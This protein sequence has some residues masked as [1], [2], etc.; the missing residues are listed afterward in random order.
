MAEAHYRIGTVARLSGLSTHVIR[1]WE[2]RYAVLAPD[3]TPG[4]ARLYDDDDVARLRF[5][6][7]AVDAGH[8][9]GTLAELST[10]ELER[11]GA[12]A[13][14]ALSYA[15]ETETFVTDIVRALGDFDGTRAE[16]ILA[17]AGRELSPRSLVIDVLG[18]LLNRIGQEWASG[19]LC[20]ASEH[21]G[22]V[23]IR[24]RLGALIREHQPVSSD[25]PVVAATPAGEL[26]ELGALLAVAIATLRGRR[27]LYL[28]PDL[29]AS[30]IAKAVRGSRSRL[31]LL[32]I[33]A[34]EKRSAVREVKALR[35]ELPATV[36]L[37]LGGSSSADVA[38]S[39]TPPLQAL[40]SLIELDE[41]FDRR[42]P[43]G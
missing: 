15:A 27:V 21:L 31:L 3:R 42:V 17:G 6:K 41:W 38:S 11:L 26:H 14:A 33:V 32:S 30:E 20:T 19:S 8:P 35:R 9:I 28:G 2:R 5:L 12:A 4:G 18:P 37:L 10:E 40:K 13:S 16:Q 24:N 29:P 43:S 34:L 39:F 23:L 1:V 36:D 25:D 7:R 22:S